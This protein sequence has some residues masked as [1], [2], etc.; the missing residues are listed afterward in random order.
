MH[1]IHWVVIFAW[2]NTIIVAVYFGMI[3]QLD[4]DK[5]PKGYQAYFKTNFVVSVIGT[6]L[7]I[8]KGIVWFVK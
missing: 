8:V 2:L 5:I 1:N 7:W 4:F 6:A 3:K